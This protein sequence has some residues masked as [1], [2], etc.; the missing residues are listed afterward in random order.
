MLAAA[1]IWHRDMNAGVQS[2]RGWV[3]FTKRGVLKSSAS[4]SHT[5]P[6]EKRRGLL[7]WCCSYRAVG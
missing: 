7:I 2:V 6:K 1:T 4:S 3:G 5:G